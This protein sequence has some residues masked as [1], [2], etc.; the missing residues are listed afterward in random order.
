MK[1]PE[2]NA[3]LSNIQN[4]AIIED[5]KYSYDNIL[6]L[7]NKNQ[8][9]LGKLVI[10]DSLNFIKIFKKPTKPFRDKSNE[11]IAQ[12]KLDSFKPSFFDRLFFLANMEL[13]WLQHSL[14]TAI[15]EDEKEYNLKYKEYLLEL[16]IWNKLNQHSVQY[17]NN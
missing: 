11:K 6:L 1:N 10:K 17:Q 9:N 3:H 12:K 5:S 13:R 8:P 2:K 4:I 7:K 14:E 15:L 16:E